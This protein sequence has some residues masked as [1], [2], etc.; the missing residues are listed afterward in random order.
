MVI[1]HKKI[2]FTWKSVGDRLVTDGVRVNL[3][4]LP[5]AVVFATVVLFPTKMSA[6]DVA[7]L[8]VA[9]LCDVV[10]T[11]LER[12][13]N[14]ALTFLAAD[15]LAALL[16]GVVTAIRESEFVVGLAFSMRMIRSANFQA[17]MLSAIHHLLARVLAEDEGD[18]ALFSAGVAAVFVNKGDLLLTT[19]RF[20]ILPASSSQ[21]VSAN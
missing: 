21:R 20:R 4:A 9:F 3:S 18:V 15:A 5:G 10:T 17:G 12:R 19:Q 7:L 14:V 1:T 2:Y 16:D 13:L 8:F 11:P 6:N